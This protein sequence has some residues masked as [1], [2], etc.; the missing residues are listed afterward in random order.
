M[1]DD[2]NR[3]FPINQT[4]STLSSGMEIFYPPLSS[5]VTYLGTGRSKVKRA[6]H[7]SWNYRDLF[8]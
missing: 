7:P 3:K 4:N 8:A 2:L 1:L 6:A 5:S